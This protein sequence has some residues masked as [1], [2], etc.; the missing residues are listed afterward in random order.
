MKFRCFQREFRRNLDVFR[1]NLD[2]FRRNLDVFDI[3]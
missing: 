1:E 3:I 2:V